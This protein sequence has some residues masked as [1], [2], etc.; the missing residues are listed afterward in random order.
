MG[1]SYNHIDQINRGELQFIF[2]YLFIIFFCDM[3][4]VDNGLKDICCCGSGKPT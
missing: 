4:T 3:V 2:I 1:R